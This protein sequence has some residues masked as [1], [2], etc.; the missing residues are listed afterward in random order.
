MKY[1][2]E[3]LDKLFSSEKELVEAEKA[4]NKRVSDIE[5]Q[6]KIVK[7]LDER[8]KAKYEEYLKANEAYL[9]EEQKL[10]DMELGL[11][12]EDEDLEYIKKFFEM[13]LQK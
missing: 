8:R 12:E 5:A 1:Y 9:K 13:L 4:E 10:G 11:D 7:Q 6:A 2:S 3:V